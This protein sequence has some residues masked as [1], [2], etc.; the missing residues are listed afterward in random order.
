M[1]KIIVRDAV[2]DDAEVLTKIHSDGWN[3]AYRGIFSDTFLDKRINPS[4]FSEQVAKRLESIVNKKETD[5]HLT[6]TNENGRVIG[7]AD[8]GFGDNGFGFGP[9]YELKGLYINPD[10]IGFGIGKILV[11]E[12]AHRVKAQG[13]D[14]FIIGCL[15]ENKSC[16]FYEKIGGKKIKEF[17]NEKLENLSETYY[18]F[19]VKKFD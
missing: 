2:I 15:S 17:K 4:V 9:M 10:F 7:F 18:E 6:A 8:G 1:I 13:A 11:T 5:I 16:G 12:F 14:K 19:D 3:Y